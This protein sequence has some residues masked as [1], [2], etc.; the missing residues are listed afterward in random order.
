MEFDDLLK[1]EDKYVLDWKSMTDSGMAV[2]D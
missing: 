1:L 2:R